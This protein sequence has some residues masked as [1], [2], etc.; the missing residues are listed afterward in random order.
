MMVQ[1][2]HKEQPYGDA[3][4]QEQQA[5]DGSQHAAF[6]LPPAATDGAGEEWDGKWIAVTDDAA[7]PT[8]LKTWL[9]QARAAAQVRLCGWGCD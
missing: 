5:G 7:R 2:E 8:R 1:K 4:P 3:G 6:T 9:L